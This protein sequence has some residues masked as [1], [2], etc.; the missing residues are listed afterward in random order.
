MKRVTIKQI[1]SQINYLNKITGNPEHPWKREGNHN[2]AQ[3]GNYH[4]SQA[5]GGVC[6]HQIVNTGGGVRTPL[7][8][9]HVPR[10]DLYNQLTAFIR[11]IELE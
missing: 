3:I 2:K 5:Y 4:L 9:G 8:P 1:E 7:S 6:L 11:G 10:R